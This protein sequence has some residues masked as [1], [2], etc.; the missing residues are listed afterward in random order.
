M[1][2]FRVQPS[3]GIDEIAVRSN[4]KLEIQDGVFQNGITHISVRRQVRNDI[5]LHY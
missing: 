2:V 1:H 4:Q 3:N 5:S